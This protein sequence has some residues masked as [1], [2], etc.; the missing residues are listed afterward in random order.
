MKKMIKRSLMLLLSLQPVTSMAE[1]VTRN[2]QVNG[3]ATASAAWLD[4][5]QGGEYIQDAYGN[6]GYTEKP[7][8]GKESVAGLQITYRID[9]RSNLVTQLLSEGRNEYTRGDIDITLPPVIPG[10]PLNLDQSP[11]SFASLG[12]SYDD[13]R[14]FLAA[15]AHKLTWLS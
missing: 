4:N 3:F 13:G 7:D 11:T 5:D 15:D 6:P 2:L 8:F 14:W 1:D 10:D 9:D 12:A